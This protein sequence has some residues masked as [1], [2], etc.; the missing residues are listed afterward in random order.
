MDGAN[1]KWL[2][3]QG[4]GAYLVSEDGLEELEHFTANNSPL[5]SDVII[6]IEVDGESGEVFLGTEKGIISYKGNA[7]QGET[8]YNNVVVYPNPVRETY[9]GPVAIKGLLE[10]TTVKIADMGGNLVFETES[11]GGQ[12]IWDGTNFNGERVATGVYMIY[13]SSADG[14]LS[15]VTKLLFIH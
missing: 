5:L 13:L 15:H 12:A 8:S 2:G 1:R 6:D 14:A 3:T 9:D 7:M 4:G 10:N 11:L